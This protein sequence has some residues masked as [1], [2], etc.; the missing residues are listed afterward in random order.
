MAN[1]KTA[2]DI[3]KYEL[4]DWIYSKHFIENNKSEK[5]ENL[6]RPFTTVERRWLKAISLDPK[7]HLFRSDYSEE[8]KDVEPLFTADDIAVLGKFEDG[9]DYSN[10][11]YQRNFE[12]IG[13]AIEY[14]TALSIEYV[15]G[16]GKVMSGQYIPYKLDYSKRNDKFRLFA[17]NIDDDSN[18]IIN[19]DSIKK[20][21]R[22]NGVHGKT[23]EQESFKHEADSTV[24]F[25]IKNERNSLERIIYELSH[26]Y[27]TV[28]KLEDDNY[29][30][31]VKYNK[32]D[33]REL[34]I[35]LMSYA[36]FIKI[37]GPD[38]IR[39]RIQ[40]KIQQQKK[41]NMKFR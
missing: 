2:G 38:K 33:M 16:R 9:D 26:Y 22:L 25:V 1:R 8:L 15:T 41:L 10:Q 19:L 23:K 30:I 6:D 11:D 5:G 14:N 34:A 40:E 35:S 21:Q 20:C 32:S 36:H 12:Q 24:V 31:T 7:F 28:E 37:Q 27:K 3:S 18:T 39:D 29:K 17:R 4:F 13:I